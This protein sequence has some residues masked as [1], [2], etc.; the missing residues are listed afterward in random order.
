MLLVSLLTGHT[1]TLPLP[2]SAPITVSV[3]MVVPVN[4][5]KMEIVSVGR[6]PYG[7]S[8][9]LRQMHI[10]NVSAKKIT[11]QKKT[12]LFAIGIFSRIFR[13]RVSVLKIVL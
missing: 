3:S 5:T 7:G 11:I 8:V 1:Y 9:R 4:T 12:L 6:L 13:N 2:T 10:G